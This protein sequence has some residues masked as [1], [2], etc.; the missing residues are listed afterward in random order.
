MALKWY[1]SEA[2][3][4]D[5]GIL[6]RPDGRIG[7]QTVCTAVSPACSGLEILVAGSVYQ[8]RGFIQTLTILTEQC[9]STIQTRSLIICRLNWLWKKIRRQVL[10]EN[11]IQN[12][13]LIGGIYNSWIIGNRTSVIFFI[14]AGDNGILLRPLNSITD[15]PDEAFAGCTSLTSFIMRESDVEGGER[16]G[17]K[18]FDGDSKLTT[19]VLPS[20][21][22]EIDSLPF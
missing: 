20:T 19:V 21:L 2:L 18:V 12:R 16:I 1:I 13:F 10:P 6:L 15:V 9:I 3:A 22:N 7:G 17:A 11:G 4:G 8:R 14:S 5:N